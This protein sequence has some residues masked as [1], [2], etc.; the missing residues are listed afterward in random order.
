MESETIYLEKKLF[1]S[2]SIELEWGFVTKKL[3]NLKILDLYFPTLLNASSHSI[4][5]IQVT[6]TFMTVGKY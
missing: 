6:Y 4:Y 2:Y 5:F 3:G 1:F